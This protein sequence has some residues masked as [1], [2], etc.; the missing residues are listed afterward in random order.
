MLMS[1]LNDI[2]SILTLGF[3]FSTDLNYLL[4]TVVALNSL[5]ARFWL[6]NTIKHINANTI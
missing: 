1:F 5:I 2:S 4:A 3:I 6:N